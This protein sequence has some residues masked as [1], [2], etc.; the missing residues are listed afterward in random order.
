MNLRLFTERNPVLLLRLFCRNSDVIVSIAHLRSVGHRLW[1]KVIHSVDQQILV[2]A[3]LLTS[4]FRVVGQRFQTVSVK[5]HHLA[6][7]EGLLS[8]RWIVSGSSEHTLAVRQQIQDTRK[9]A[10]EAG[11]AN[12]IEAQHKKVANHSLH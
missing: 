1:V 6:S 8:R 2:M 11:G 7:L 10:E 4:G 12:R 9:R 5:S 3:Y